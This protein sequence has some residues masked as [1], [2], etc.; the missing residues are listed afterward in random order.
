MRDWLRLTRLL[1]LRWI[2]IHPLRSLLAVL[3]VAGGVSLAMSVILTTS[4]VTWSFAHFSEKV[5]FGAQL[6]VIGATARG[7]LDGRVAGEVAATPGVSVAVPTVEAI[8]PVISPSRRVTV[9][10][11]GIGGRTWGVSPQV[12][13]L[14]DAFLMT[15]AGPLPLGGAP[16]EPALAGVAGGDVVVMPLA[17]SQSL[18]ARSGRLDAVYVVP[19]KGADLSSLTR[20][21]QKAVGPWNAVV[22]AG[23]LP[24]EASV[25]TQSFLPLLGLLA[26]LAVGVSVVLVHDIVDLAFSERRRS[27]AVVAALGGSPLAVALPATEVVILGLAGG[28][29]GVGGAALVARTIVGTIDALVHQLAGVPLSIHLS[30][31]VALAAPMG[32]VLV[33]LVAAAGPLRRARAIDVAAEL[34]GRDAISVASDRLRVGR[35]AIYSALMAIGLAGCWMSSLHGSLAPWQYPVGIASFG[36]TVVAAMLAVGNLAPLA[37]HLARGVATAGHAGAAVR[38]ALSNLVRSPRRTGTM[39]VA[40]AGA[41]GVAFIAASYSR[42]ATEG[43]VGATKVP[44]ARWVYVS[45][46]STASVTIDTEDR[47][48]PAELAALAHVPGVSRVVRQVGVLTGHSASSV[49]GVETS[50]DLHVAGLPLVEGSASRALL[51]RGEALVGTAL[52]RRQH[53]RPGS[54]VILDTPGGLARIPVAGIWEVGDF[55]GSSVFISE[56]EMTRLYGSQPPT[57]VYAYAR[58]GVP[59]GELARRIVSAGIAVDVHAA[60]PSQTQA[61]WVRSVAGQIAPFWALQRALTLLAFVAVLSTFVLAGVQRRKEYGALSAVGFSPRDLSKMVITEGALVGASGTLLGGL[62]GVV[63][64]VGLIAI[65]PL[66][67]GYRNPFVLAPA[68]WAGYGAVAVAVTLAASLLPAWRAAHIPVLDALREE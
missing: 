41:V 17:M 12:A 22:P 15:D 14:R 37:L 26:V 6:R 56:Q 10:A 59:L 24:P 62:L 55:N 52:A 45:K 50:D 38:L 44:Q 40:V 49:I 34:S 23:S 36:L 30:V 7:G 32:G 48:S 51:L 21:L 20:R 43:I 67:V 25:V 46:G 60:T 54:K 64:S 53:L 19:A 18:F 57:N 65:V 58:P 28:V 31:P 61:A 68:Y 5:A 39:A 66:V 29:I 11:L 33:S 3:A 35:A 63:G 13:G 4:S 1:G 16:V 47:F 8:T 42:S 9:V 2:R 27:M